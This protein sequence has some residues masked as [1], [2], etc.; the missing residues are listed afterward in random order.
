MR[1]KCLDC[2][3]LIVEGSRCRGCQ[4]RYRSSYSRNGWAQQVKARD[5]GCCRR[6]GTTLGV[7]A[8]HIVPLSQGG[9]DTLVNGLTL[10]HACHQREHHAR[11]S[12]EV[13]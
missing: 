4:E 12:A 2:P 3:T 5:G 11:E 9:A 13:G 10:C 8:H 7:E 1:R 6:C